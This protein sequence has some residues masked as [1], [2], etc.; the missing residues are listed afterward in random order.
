MLSCITKKACSERLEAS[1]KGLS[2]NQA[3]IYTRDTSERGVWAIV[4]DHAVAVVVKHGCVILYTEQWAFMSVCSVHCLQ[5]YEMRR[6]AWI[7][8]INCKP[9]MVTSLFSPPSFL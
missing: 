9:T 7:V 6:L 8:G 3:K 5:D 4:G 2:P 1:Q